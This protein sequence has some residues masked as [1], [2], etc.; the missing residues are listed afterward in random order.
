MHMPIE[1]LCIDADDTLWYNER[2]FKAAER[3]FCS[4][5]GAFA[6]DAVALERLEA[7]GSANV[8]LYGFGAKGFTLSM[9]EAAVSLA[10]DALTA[11]C[12]SELINLGRELHSYPIELLDGVEDT[13]AILSRRVRLRLLTKGDIVHQ[14]AKLAASG[15]GHFFEGVDIVSGKDRN[16]F[17]QLFARCGVRPAFA[18]MAGDSIRSDILP[19]L[20]AGG[21]GVLIPPEH[22]AHHERAVEP[23]NE[24]R[25]VKLDRFSELS[26]WVATMANG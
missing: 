3:A 26:N 13:L 2:H 10:G 14:E 20:A 7:M 21:W 11:K 22:I 23:V 9:I 5:V 25:F 12:L 19:A 15:L 6:D 8:R 1:L 18:A 17:E 24:S 4:V 16:T